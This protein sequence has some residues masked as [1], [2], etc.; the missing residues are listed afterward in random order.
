VN[1]MIVAVD[2]GGSNEET[3]SKYAAGA[4]IKQYPSRRQQQRGNWDGLV[5]G[6]A[7]FGVFGS[8]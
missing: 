2:A 1:W 7:F 3:Y 6:S 5:D 4:R 8:F